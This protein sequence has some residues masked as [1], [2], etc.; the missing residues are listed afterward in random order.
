MEDLYFL[1]LASILVPRSLFPTPHST[2]TINF[3]QG[4]GNV[5]FV[6]K[7][8]KKELGVIV[9]DWIVCRALSKAGFSSKV[10]QKK[11]KLRPKHIEDCLD[12][13]K[14]HQN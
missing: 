11:P 1:F 2:L 6:V 9:C 10:K 13:A 14:R 5:A 8:V 12:F 7:D 4:H 3:L